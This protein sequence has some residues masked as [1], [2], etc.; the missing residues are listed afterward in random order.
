M[1]SSR[2]QP[3]IPAALLLGALY[4]IVGRVFAA[5]V[6]H[7][8]GWR[9]AAWVVCGVAFAA[10]VAYEHFNL[11]HSPRLVAWHAAVAVAIG[12]FLLA[13]AAMIRSL[14]TTSALRPIWLLAIFLWPAITAV[15]AFLVAL[16]AAVILA[17]LWPKVNSD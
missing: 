1:H 2:H 10:H 4:V 17:R 14:W 13:F 6:T 3:W 9:R 12:A 16:A 8:Q 15:P 5:P 11:R 7:V